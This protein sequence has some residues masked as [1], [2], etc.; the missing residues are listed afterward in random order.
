[1]YLSPLPAQLT[2]R[3]IFTLIM[4]LLLPI[5]LRTSFPSVNLLLTTTVVW[6][7]IPLVVL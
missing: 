1:L 3:I 2:F 5:L 4:F 6:N 7:L